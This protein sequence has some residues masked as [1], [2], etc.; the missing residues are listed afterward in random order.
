MSSKRALEER[1]KALENMF[2]EKENEKL[3][4]KLREEKERDAQRKELFDVTRISD[5]GVLDNLIDIGIRAETWLAI[6][7]AS[8]RSDVASSTLNAI[9]GPRTPTMVAPADGCTRAGPK[10]GV[11]SPS[12][13]RADSAESPPRR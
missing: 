7:L 8:V 2:F 13:M 11:I 3:L 10:S 6:S 4:A 5:D 1:R 9:S 12:S